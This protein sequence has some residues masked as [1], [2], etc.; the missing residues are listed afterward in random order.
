MGK[1][2]PHSGSEQ[3]KSEN[4]HR[5]WPTVLDLPAKVPPTPERSRDRAEQSDPFSKTTGKCLKIGAHLGAEGPEP[6]LG[7]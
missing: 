3:L 4:R 1:L 7:C 2:K 6:G 5:E